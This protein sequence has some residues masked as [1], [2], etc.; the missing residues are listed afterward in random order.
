MGF[1]WP[2]FA[3]AGIIAVPPLLSLPQELAVNTWVNYIPLVLAV[4]LYWFLIAVWIDVRVIERRRPVHS[5]AVR[6][7]FRAA[8]ALTAL[9]FVLFLGKDLL[10]GWQEGPHGA[11]GLTAWLALVSIILTTEVNFF[12]RAPVITG[13]RTTS[14]RHP[15]S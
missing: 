12:R 15:R 3:A 13:T 5:R 6:I 1:Q 4:G 14:P 9:L 7:V 2:A 8:F 11:Y 10:G